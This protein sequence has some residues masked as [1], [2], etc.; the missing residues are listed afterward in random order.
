ML[1]QL[2]NAVTTFTD[3]HLQQD[4]ANEAKLAA[5]E[6]PK[7]VEDLFLGLKYHQLLNLL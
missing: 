4:A 5:V 3:I 1:K 2:A 6:E 7:K